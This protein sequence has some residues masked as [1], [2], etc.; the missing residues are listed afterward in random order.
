MKKRMMIIALIIL[1]AAGAVGFQVL[2]RDETSKTPKEESVEKEKAAVKEATSDEGRQAAQQEE[3]FVLL[4]SLKKKKDELER[5]L[6]I[7]EEGIT[8]VRIKIPSMNIDTE[9][10]PVGLLDNGE[11]E[12]PKGTEVT[13]W[14][15]KGF[16]PGA[17][18]NA[19]IAGHV[20]SKE[21]PAVFFYLKN[22]AIGE[23]IIVTDTNGVEKTFIVKEKESYKAEEAPIEKIFGPDDERNLNL[24]TCTGTF[25]YDD[26]LYPDRLVI[27]T[28]L[29]NQSGEQLLPQPS[30]PAHVEYDL[31]SISWHAVKNDNI[32][33]YRVYKKGPSDEKFKHLASISD[34]ERKNFYDDNAEKGTQYYV[35]S[36]TIAGTESE[37]SKIVES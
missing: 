5:K 2:A 28:E 24:I 3:E 30:A 6:E 19:V 7:Q 33:G 35:T 11:M 1:L 9:V 13:G 26:H 17:K 10:I 31:G 15:S 12:V 8:P 20:D 36:V 4:D 37:A 32:M 25:N 22:L 21:G 34:H 27:Y 23:K 18:G 16:Q 29:L 14:Y